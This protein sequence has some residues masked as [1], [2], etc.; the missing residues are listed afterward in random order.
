VEVV[1]GC[2]V[3]V[4]EVVTMVAVWGMLVVVVVGGDEVVTTQI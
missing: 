4:V 1:S 3:G 2:G